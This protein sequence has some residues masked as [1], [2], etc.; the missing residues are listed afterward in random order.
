MVNSIQS[1]DRWSSKELI[2]RVHLTI[3]HAQWFNHQKSLSDGKE[4]EWR[5]TRTRCI[6]FE[7]RSYERNAMNAIERV[8]LLWAVSR[9]SNRAL[10]VDYLE[11]PDRIKTKRSALSNAQFPLCR[12]TYGWIVCLSK[13]GHS[14]LCS[15]EVFLPKLEKAVRLWRRRPFL[16]KD[17]FCW[18]FQTWKKCPQGPKGP[19][20]NVCSVHE[21]TCIP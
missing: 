2:V 17:R 21:K 12:H 10:Q 14:R 13:E 4:C 7:A 19:R 20:G 16:T 9:T 3:L 5:M 15:L 11:K 6:T 18:F 1:E 8:D